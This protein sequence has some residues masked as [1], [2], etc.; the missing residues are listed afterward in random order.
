MTGIP[1]LAEG[2]TL[3]PATDDPQTRVLKVVKDL[4]AE[5]RIKTLIADR[6][7]TF[8]KPERWATPLR[9]LGIDNILNLHPDQRGVQGTFQGALQIDGNLYCPAMTEALKDFERLARPLRNGRPAGGV[10]QA[11]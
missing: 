8:A 3:T 5:D 10:L 9:G 7:Y 1:Y 4:K 6:G 11:C 2:I